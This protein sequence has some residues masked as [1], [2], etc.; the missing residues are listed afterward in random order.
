VNDRMTQLKSYLDDTARYFFAK[1]EGMDRDRYTA[2]RDIRYILDKA[3]ND[4]ILCMVDVAEECLK[5]HGRSVPPT[6]RETVLA[7]YEFVGDAAT[8]VA[9]LVKHRNE[10][11]HHYLRVNWQNV[12]TVRNK[13]ADILAFAEKVLQTLDREL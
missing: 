2:D 3:I 4:I 12:V 8:K 9:P 11:I 6:Y 7:C 1:A 10:M 5:S 13:T